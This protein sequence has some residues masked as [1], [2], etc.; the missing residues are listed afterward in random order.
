MKTLSR[1]LLAVNFIM[2]ST[3][4]S[5]SPEA[6]KEDIEINAS[7]AESVRVTVAGTGITMASALLDATTN[8]EI[9]NNSGN[10]VSYEVKQIKFAVLNYDAPTE[11]E[12]YFSGDIGFSSSMANQP[13]Y[14]CS[15]SPLNV[16]HVA[17]TGDFG[18]NPCN[19]LLTDLSTILLEDNKM[20]LF[21]TGTYTKAQV[22]FDL[23]VTVI[24]TVIARH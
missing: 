2:I 16:T 12:I 22:S 9:A 7:L 18:I 11:D 10:I 4:C 24:I 23:R 6:Q 14:T 17:G 3:M 20:K 19:T 8:D 5:N 1:I 15:I 21:M 13:E